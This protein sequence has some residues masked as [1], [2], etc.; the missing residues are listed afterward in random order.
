MI[1]DPFDYYANF[2]SAGGN[3]RRTFQQG[4]GNDYSSEKSLKN[5]ISEIISSGA[6]TESI[7]QYLMELGLDEYEIKSL[8]YEYGYSQSDLEEIFNPQEPEGQSAETASEDDEASYEEDAESY[9]D[10]D[11]DVSFGLFGNQ[12]PE[13]RYGNG[14]NPLTIDQFMRLNSGQDEYIRNPM[15]D[16][17]P[18]DL[19]A[20]GNVAGALFGLASGVN[21]LFGGKTDPSTGLKEGF[22]RDAKVKRAR[23]K[24]AAPYYYNYKV[25]INAGDTNSYAADINDLYDAAK[26]RGS[27]RTKE[28]YNADEIK[29]SRIQP[30]SKP[31]RYNFLYANRPINENLYTESQRNSLKNFTPYSEP[32]VT[33][34]YYPMDFK[35][36]VASGI[37]YRKPSIVDNPQADTPVNNTQSQPFTFQDLEVTPPAKSIVER[38]KYG[39]LPKAQEGIGLGLVLSNRSF[40]D[41]NKPVQKPVQKPV[42]N[43]IPKNTNIYLKDPRTINLTTGKKINPNVDLFSGEY[44]LGTI[45]SI[46]ERSKFDNLSKEDAYT[47]LAIGLQE[48]KLGKNDGNIGHVKNLNIEGSDQIAR[49]A[50][51]YK[52]KMKYADDLG[53]KDPVLRIQTYNGLGTIVPETEQGYHGFRMKKI[54]GVPLPKEG[55]N[56]RKNPLYGK[57]IT[58]L[59][60]NMLMKNENLRSIVDSYY[61]Q[62]GGEQKPKTFEEWAAEDPMNR[63]VNFP[64][65]DAYT[66]YENNFYASKQ[67]SIV[68]NPQADMPVVPPSSIGPPLS[69][70][71]FQPRISGYAAGKE[72]A[73]NQTGMTVPKTD[74][75]TQNQMGMA[76]P[77][78]VMVSNAP[79]ATNLP[80]INVTETSLQSEMQPLKIPQLPM[81]DYNMEIKPARPFDKSSLK[82]TP[83]PEEP[84]PGQPEVKITNRLEGDFNRFMDSRF[85]QG[86]GKVSNF[87]VNA[88]D[89]VNEIYKNK[90][91]ANAEKRLYEMTMADNY[92]GYNANPMNKK[93]TYDVN[94]GLAEQNNYVNFPRY[95]DGGL[96]LNEDMYAEDNVLDLD[97]DSIAELISLG[98]N[99]EIL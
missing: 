72:D 93:G 94:T 38:K 7:V 69:R 18:M 97:S 14:F 24:A 12:L 95:Q 15:A 29:Y 59:R 43:N 83:L 57:R 40:D 17:L 92:Y 99:I 61:K 9:E 41:F 26:N 67:P 46:L 5:Q 11:S 3:L 25:K 73:Q 42:V 19:G 68:N 52:D 66:D 86:Y 91:R 90:K 77:E 50:K 1:V 37:P 88:A 32:L 78:E 75:V 96:F 87:A 6:S 34:P 45:K 22:F 55:I 27:L 54:Y 36:E 79:N 85:M 56:M 16:Y 62:G 39:G 49:L 80:Q 71:Y 84:K 10:D 33:V 30:G 70:F 76:V 4:G 58:D 81:P 65:M 8:L 98:A 48:T 60:D 13:A 35:P 89:F 2:Y 31:D 51:A 64:T 44:D 47:L 23:Q 82:P 28:Q 74:P 53:I 63:K 20:K 21:D